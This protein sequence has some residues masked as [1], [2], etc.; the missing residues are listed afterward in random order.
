M[1]LKYFSIFLLFLLCAIQLQGGYDVGTSYLILF[2][3]WMLF[4][5]VF[6]PRNVRSVLL[7]R[8]FLSIYI[9]L[10]IYFLTSILYCPPLTGINRCVSFFSTISPIIMYELI[11]KESRGI[12]IAFLIFISL[13]FIADFFIAYQYLE[14]TGAEKLRDAEDLGDEFYIMKFAF[15]LC[16][17]ISL[18]IPAFCGLF[19]ELKGRVILRTLMVAILLGLFIF[20]L[21]AQFMTA[22]LV[23]LIG[24][25]LEI[26]YRKGLSLIRSSII[27]LLVGGASLYLILPFA[28]QQLR[29][30][31]E[32]QT[33][34]IRLVE[35][36]SVLTGNISQASDFN[37]RSNLTTKSF[38]TFIEN[39]ILGVNYKLDPKRHVS[40]QGIGNH[41]AWVDFLAKFGFC[42]IFIFYFLFVSSKRQKKEIGSPVPMIMFFF[43]G[44]FN[45]LFLFPQMCAAYLLNPLMYGLLKIQK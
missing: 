25:F 9:F 1:L 40:E 39:P 30:N 27:V 42:S 22:I 34:L 33:V 38:S 10:I 13:I 37:E 5:I 12:R 23:A 8:R 32:Y 2:G 31:G 14:I 16:Y 4:L 17:A 29:D 28:I 11:K 19:Y 18:I 15:N 26:V 20:L 3:I 36:E 35:I 6:N 7:Q 41:A 43:L 21:R 45:P 44:F 24:V